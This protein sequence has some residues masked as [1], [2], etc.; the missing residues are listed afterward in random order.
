MSDLAA[1]RLPMPGGFLPGRAG[2]TLAAR[3]STWAR[4][5]LFSSVFNTVLTIVVLLLAGLVLPPLFRWAVTHATI[6]GMTRAACTGDGACWTFI[7]VRFPLFI[8]GNYPSDQYWRVDLVVALLVAFCT[9]VLRDGVRHRWLYVLLLL[10]VF[11]SARGDAAGRRR[12]RARLCRHV[13]VG[14]ADARPDRVVRHRGG[15]AAAGDRAG[16][17]PALAIAGRTDAVGW[18]HRGVARRAAADRAV[19]VGGGDAAI[20]ARRRFGRSA[21]ARHGGAGVVQRRLH[22]RGGAR[23]TARRRPGAGGSRGLRSG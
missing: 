6:S 22:G 18:L 14:R 21:V 4:R 2:R 5:N 11:P 20:H 12:V 17:R 3:R 10:T 1:P 19:H 16:V 15:I 8:Y 13:A 7:R 9:P 23:R